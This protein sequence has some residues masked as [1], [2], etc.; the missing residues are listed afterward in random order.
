MIPVLIVPIL[1][2]SD[3]LRR[4][5]ASIDHEVEHL[6]VINNGAFVDAE[7]LKSSALRVSVINLPS[8]LGVAGSWNLGIKVTP[9]APWWLIANFDVVW[10]VGSLER[11]AAL[12]PY[13]RLCLSGG[14]PPWCA[15]SVGEQVVSKVGL[16]DEG[17]HPAYFEDNDY[18]VRVE[19]A[20]LIVE[21]TSIPVHH[22]NSSTLKRGFEQ[23]NI[24][25]FQA[26]ALYWRS[27][28]AA[29][30]YSQGSWNLNIRRRNSWD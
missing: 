23:H 13:D 9:F 15:F 7:E 21:H 8:N 10:P 14:T 19:H 2:G 29:S 24:S 22:D 6:V 11:W 4:M 18:Q 27:K 25:S 5:V 30:D 20:G 28:Q 3:L 12:A 26:N 1:T 17:F 16:F